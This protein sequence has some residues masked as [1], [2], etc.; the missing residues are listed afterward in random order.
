MV[1]GPRTPH[2]QPLANDRVHHRQGQ[3]TIRAWA[4]GIHRR[5]PGG[6]GVGRVMTM[7]PR[8]AG[9][10]T[11]GHRCRLL[12]RVF[13]PQRNDQPRTGKA[14]GGRAFRPAHGI[15]IA[16]EAGLRA[17]VRANWLAPH[18]V[19]EREAMPSPWSRPMVLA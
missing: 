14:L 11:K 10:W 9:R 15:E 3:R 13:L 12:V 1:S 16:F 8:A 19:E 5:R 6:A 7:M 17:D 2:V 18:P 4:D